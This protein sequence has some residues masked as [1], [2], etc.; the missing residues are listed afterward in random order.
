MEEDSRAGEEEV[1]KWGSVDVARVSPKLIGCEVREKGTG[2][3]GK[4]RYV[5]QAMVT[6]EYAH[7]FKNLLTLDFAKH[8]EIMAAEYFYYDE[9]NKDEKDK[10]EQEDDPS[11]NKPI[12][13]QLCTC[14][15]VSLLQIGCPKIK[16]EPTC[17]S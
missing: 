5:Y 11:K 12:Y 14:P 2:L 9:E 4:I 16:G 7:V 10:K 6:I 1:S 3:V 17:N 13:D 15:I 8:Y